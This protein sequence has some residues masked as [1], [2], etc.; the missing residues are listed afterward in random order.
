LPLLGGAHESRARVGS[1]AHTSFSTPAA[2]KPF[3]SAGA[4]VVAVGAVEVGGA[5]VG[6]GAAVTAAGAEVGE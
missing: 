6:A 1:E 4:V 2:V 5:T 3:K